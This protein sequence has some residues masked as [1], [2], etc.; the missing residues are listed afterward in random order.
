M[1]S[2]ELGA[3]RLPQWVKLGRGGLSICSALL[4]GTSKVA[5]LF[6]VPAAQ[7]TRAAREFSFQRQASQW[8]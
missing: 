6:A 8:L 2:I 4:S 3:T 5:S 1:I 7:R